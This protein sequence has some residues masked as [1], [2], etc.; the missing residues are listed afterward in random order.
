MRRH[1]RRCRVHDPKINTESKGTWK[2]IYILP[3]LQLP[4][5]TP[6]PELQIIQLVMLF[7]TWI[8]QTV[9]KS[10]REFSPDSCQIH[11]GLCNKSEQL[12]IHKTR[13]EV[14]SGCNV[15]GVSR[16]N[17]QGDV[18]GSFPQL[19]CYVLVRKRLRVCNHAPSYVSVCSML[20][21]R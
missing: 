18:W 19:W 10:N 4:S 9:S 20:D 3:R 21:V 16:Q 8:P 11:R 5:R 6:D 14:H 7:P 2:D 15:Q 13:E 17:N 12:C 1:P